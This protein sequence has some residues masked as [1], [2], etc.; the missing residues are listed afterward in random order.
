MEKIKIHTMRCK[1]CYYCVESCP[2][3]A[4]AVS[5]HKNDKGYNYVE[6]KDELCV[7]CGTCFEVCPDFV[8]EVLE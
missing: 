5:A 3:H 4:L 1:G 6:V 7:A 2:K 8:Y